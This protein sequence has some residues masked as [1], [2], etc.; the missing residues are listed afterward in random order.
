M[1]I[2]WLKETQHWGAYLI[3]LPYRIC[4]NADVSWTL[5]S[6][7]ISFPEISKELNQGR[8]ERKQLEEG[9]MHFE[10]WKECG[11]REWSRDLFWVLCHW[12]WRLKSDFSMLLFLSVSWFS[13]S[14]AMW[15]LL[16]RNL[17]MN[18]KMLSNVQIFV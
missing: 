11:R 18:G 12:M 15:F 8:E 2:D 17:R 16:W 5:V 6:K 13:N 9:H 14:Y 10:W 1:V 7:D 4:H 3:H